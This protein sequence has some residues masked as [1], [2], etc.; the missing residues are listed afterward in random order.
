MPIKLFPSTTSIHYQE[1][2][3]L[4]K[5]NKSLLHFLSSRKGQAII[6]ICIGTDRSTGDALGPL[7]GSKLIEKN[8]SSFPIFGTL[9]TPVHALNLTDT[10]LHIRDTFDNP[11][12]IGIDASL[13]SEKNIG[14]ITLAKGPLYPG[15]AFHKKLPSVGNIH[16]TGIVNT[17]D[18]MDYMIL[19]NT[20]LSIVMDMAEVIASSIYQTE[21]NFLR[22]S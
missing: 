18:Y 16:I 7:I 2:Q 15:S 20:R 19:Q 10:L 1:N 9:D 22:I 17:C 6:L 12:I 11:F 14:S 4:K 5:L 8:L 21:Q 3:A 13:G